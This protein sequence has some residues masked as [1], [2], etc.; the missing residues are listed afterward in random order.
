ML[1]G[2]LKLD[3]L[4]IVRMTIALPINP[5]N[6]TNA[7]RLT[8]IPSYISLSLRGKDLSVGTVLFVALKK[9]KLFGSD[10]KTVEI[11]IWKKQ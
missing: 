6:I 5:A 1:H 2:V 8:K 3:F 7:N 11:S 10:G 4:H 9:L